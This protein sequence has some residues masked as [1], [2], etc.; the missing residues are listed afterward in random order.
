V[1]AKLTSKQNFK[2]T[3]PRLAVMSSS[4]AH[5]NITAVMKHWIDRALWDWILSYSKLS[6]PND[7]SL[8]LRARYYYTTTKLM[9]NK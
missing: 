9:K 3:Q 2:E 8:N 5:D 1:N 4:S 6:I 7:A